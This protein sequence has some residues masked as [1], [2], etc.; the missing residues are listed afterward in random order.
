MAEVLVR[1]TEPIRG[2]H[3][4]SYR[5][6]ASGAVDTDGLWKGWI[7]F[8]APDGAAFRSPRETEQPNRIAL[9]YWA[10]GLTVAYLEGAL[11]RALDALAKPTVGSVAD[12]SSIF[13]DPAP[14]IRPRASHPILDPF[15]IY[16]QGK[17]VLRGQLAALSRD[18]L[19]TIIES[20]DLP[21]TVST[22]ATDRDLIDGIVVAVARANHR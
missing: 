4:G 10:E 16:A 15:A 12:A 9:V 14:P 21:V 8:V 13:N 19:R 6:Q 11:R 5:A 20:Y 7:E 17:D 3:G 18:H 2:D 22:S 1:F